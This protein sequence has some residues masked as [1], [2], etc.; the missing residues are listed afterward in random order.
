ASPK[1]FNNAVVKPYPFEFSSSFLNIASFEI[2]CYLLL[3]I[4]MLFYKNKSLQN[5]PFISFSVVFS[6]VML[7][8]IGFIVPNAGSIIRYRSIYFPLLIIPLLC[9]IKFNN[10]SRKE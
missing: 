7:L 3:F 5:D 6:I 9:S 4:A 1:A 10:L 2:I 8:F